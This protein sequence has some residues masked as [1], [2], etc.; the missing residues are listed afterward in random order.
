MAIDHLSKFREGL[1][2]IVYIPDVVRYLIDVYPDA[3]Q[4]EAAGML[5]DLMRGTHVENV[6]LLGIR[7]LGGKLCYPGMTYEHNFEHIQAF[8]RLVANKQITI[9]ENGTLSG[10]IDFSFSDKH[11]KKIYWQ[12]LGFD[13]AQVR[14]FFELHELAIDIDNPPK[15]LSSC[16]ELQTTPTR[17]HKESSVSDSFRG[18]DTALMLIAGLAVTLVKTGD[19]FKRGGKL[20]KSEVVRAAEQA[21]AQ[22]GGDV[23]VTSKAITNCLTKALSR[24]ASKLE[25]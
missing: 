24:H 19:K 11:N 23:A 12:D 20:N 5:I 10:E 4:S 9:A 15:Y 2:Q 18:E 14:M 16:V 21:I 25:E 7:D 1:K 22:Y 6:P 13:R 8:Y 3:S 17:D